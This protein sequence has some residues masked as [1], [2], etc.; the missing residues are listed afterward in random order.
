VHV[1]EQAGHVLSRVTGPETSA[2]FSRLHHA[3]GVHV[4][5]DARV[6]AFEGTDGLENV[7]CDDGRVRADVALVAAGAIPN[8]ILAREAGLACDD[9]I[10]VDEYCRTSD[11]AIFAAGDCTR[12]PSPL[13]AAKLRLESVQNAV[14][15]A[16]AA[17][18]NMCD[19]A[20]PYR[21][22]PWFWSQQFE[23][24][25]QT[26][27]LVTGYDEV[28]R[29]SGTDDEHFTLRYHRNGQLVAVEAV[30]MPGEYLKARREMARA[31]GIEAEHGGRRVA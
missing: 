4:R 11:A 30:N 29:I 25:L 14:D 12:H 5:C 1:L 2:H 3:R 16:A 26:A 8:D 18:V 7:V 13:Q 22:I 21:T 27:G 15:Q 10:L 31:A 6:V 19:K 23:H 24:K 28:R 17:A 20:Q 9:G